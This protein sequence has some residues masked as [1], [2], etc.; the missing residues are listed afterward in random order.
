MRDGGSERDGLGARTGLGVFAVGA[1]AVLC[2]A[3]WPLLVGVV[4][5]IGAATI[6]GGGGGIAVA[7]LAALLIVARIRRR[8]AAPAVETESEPWDRGAASADDPDMSSRRR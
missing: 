7:I 5:S 3:A 1:L 2:C 8:S 4:A 6:F